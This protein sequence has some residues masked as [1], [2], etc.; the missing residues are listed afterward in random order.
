MGWNGA[1]INDFIC[2]YYC[3]YSVMDMYVSTVGIQ[4]KKQLLILL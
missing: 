1:S 4:T 2:V 3:H